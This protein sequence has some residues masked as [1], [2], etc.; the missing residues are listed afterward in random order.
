[1]LHG[2]IKTYIDDAV[3]DSRNGAEND[4]YLTREEFGRRFRA[5]FYDPAFRAEDA[6]LER[7]EAIAWDAYS[8]GRRA[9]SP[10]KADAVRADPDYALFVEWR[11]ARNA[12]HRND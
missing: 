4:E 2:M 11:Q 9:T 6:A 12:L 5:R 3:P 8:N 7:I 1:M 10:D